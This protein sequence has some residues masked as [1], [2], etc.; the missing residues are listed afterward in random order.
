M[1]IRETFEV[2]MLGCNCTIL[3]DSETKQALV[4]DPGAE[5]PRILETLRRHGLTVNAVLHTHAHIDHVGA[6]AEVCQATGAIGYLHDDDGPLYQALPVQAHMLG[7]GRLPRSYEMKP[8]QDGTSYTAGD[9]ELGVLHTPGHTMGSC[10]FLL[11]KARLLL[12]G[13]TLFRRGVGRT[14]LG[15]DWDTLVASIQERLFALPDDVVVIPGHGPA[16][17]VGEEKRLNPFLR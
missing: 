8:L 2:G 12:S 4:I 6:T 13:D 11:E 15:G 9:V 10:C 7:L 17:T 14:D 3:A 16:T 1:L 5:G